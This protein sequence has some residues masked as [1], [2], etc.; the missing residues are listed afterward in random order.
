VSSF[1]STEARGEG[2]RRRVPRTC[3]DAAMQ[4]SFQRRGRRFQKKA[5]ADVDAS[6]RGAGADAAAAAAHAASRGPPHPSPSPLDAVAPR[7]DVPAT[8]VAGTR[9]GLHGHTLVSSG[10]ADLDNLLGGGVPLGTVVALGTDGDPASAG[11]NACTLLRYFVAEGCASGHAGMWIHPGGGGG[12]AGS[13][14]SRSVA[15]TLPRLVVDKARADD[16]D[17]AGDTDTAGDANGDG[18]R[19]AWQYR[20]YLRQGKALDDGRVG[21]ARDG[22]GAGLSTSGG[23]GGSNSGGGRRNDGGVRRLPEICHRFDLTRETDPAAV[24]AADLACVAFRTPPAL[25]ERR[26]PHALDVD[27]DYARAYERCRA[28]VDEL[29]R[30]DPLAVGRLAIHAG[31]DTSIDA[32]AARSTARFLRALR[33]LLR[34]TRACAVCVVSTRH[35]KSDDH[36]CVELASLTHVVDAR[37]DVE[38]LPGAPCAMEQTLPDPLL[39]VG[40]VH[41]VKIAFP[42]VVGASPL[43]RMDRTYALQLRR[44][45]MAIAPLQLSPE[46]HR[47]GDHRSAAGGAGGVRTSNL[48][49]GGRRE[50]GSGSTGKKSASGGLCGSGPAGDPRND[51]LDF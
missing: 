12:R 19:I 16:D 36:S 25:G 24:E 47:S 14:A 4:S 45:R 2:C 13:G 21:G 23:G 43:T 41:A 40:L 44:R 26:R 31:V 5:A 28:F 42:G 6:D 29:R 27:G 11:G 48:G 38:S 22:L 49:V 15:R 51:P 30:R 50:A 18:L 1:T 37:V 20:R 9:P 34:G 17:A 10:L 7:V 32:H 8:H 46:D 33:G 35:I 39:C 3:E